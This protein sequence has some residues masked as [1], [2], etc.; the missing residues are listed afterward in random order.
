ML[1]TENDLQAV[2][3]QMKKRR[4]VLLA[5][6]GIALVL[7]VLN[8]VVLRLP[9][10]ADIKSGHQNDYLYLY[11]IIALAALFFSVFWTDLFMRPVKA[12]QRLLTHALHGR[13][14][15][16]EYTYR[17]RESETVMRDAVKLV[18]LTM[19]EGDPKDEKNE[20]LLY[21]DALLPFPEWK[22]GETLRLITHDKVIVGWER[23]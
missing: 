19:T 22:T 2:T 15:Q 13:T 4:A 17:D 1:Y 6:L 5:V 18:P 8:Y 9:V 7:M 11:Y 21:Y 12:Y 14:R 20:R 23:I 3:A 10:R 16:Y